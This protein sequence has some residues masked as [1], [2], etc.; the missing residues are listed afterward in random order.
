[1]HTYGVYQGVRNISFSKS[2]A[3]V[4]NEWSHAILQDS[5]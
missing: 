3:P 1:M 2:F 5:V 4:L